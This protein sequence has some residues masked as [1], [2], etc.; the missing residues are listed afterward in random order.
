MA[1]K[2]GALVDFATL[3]E[4]IEFTDL[5]TQHEF[6]LADPENQVSLVHRDHVF[7]V[8][9]HIL[10]IGG[11]CFFSAPHQVQSDNW[12]K[13]IEVAHI[14]N[15]TRIEFN[16]YIPDPASMHTVVCYIP[17]ARV[18]LWTRLKMVATEKHSDWKKVSAVQMSRNKVLPR[19]FCSASKANILD[20]TRARLIK[21]GLTTHIPPDILDLM[22]WSDDSSYTRAVDVCLTLGRVA[23]FE[24]LD[25]LVRTQPVLTTKRVVF[26]GIKLGTFQIIKGV[27]ISRKLAFMPM[28]TTTNFQVAHRFAGDDGLILKIELPLGEHVLDVKTYLKSHRAHVGAYIQTENELLVASG[29]SIILTKEVRCHPHRSV[30]VVSCTLVRLKLLRRRVRA[31]KH[32]V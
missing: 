15:T 28:A 10:E 8:G 32:E 26:K 12:G 5:T 6:N 22:A 13:I 3:P 7:I 25:A 23:F 17:P 14:S 27:L 9:K 31:L 21:A 16:E 1:T 19:A 29:G 4:V 30:C 11:V 2:R 18:L 20:G 24:R